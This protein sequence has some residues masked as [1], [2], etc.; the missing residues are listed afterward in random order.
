MTLTTSQW[1]QRYL[2]QAS[3]TQNLRNYIYNQVLIQRADKILDIGCGTGV[4]ENELNR[5]TLSHVYGLDIDLKPLHLA[6]EYAP[7]SNFTVGDCS[8]LPYRN[9][10][11]N[12]TLCHFL[13]LWVKDTLK[14]IE[15]MARVTRPKGFVLALAEPDYGGRIDYP[16]EL[17]RIG[18][19]QINALRHQGANPL[20]GR[21]LRSLFSHAG[22]INIEIGVLGGQW[23]ENE[24]GQDF[25]L[26][27]E[28][29]QSDLNQN[30]EFIRQAGK[31][32]AIDSASRE[33]HQRI[34]FVP[35]FYAIGMIPGSN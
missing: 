19:W 27:W 13:L 21:K 10:E 7:K 5:L 9:G 23:G 16:S 33:M 14:S 35:T 8:S 12:I 22:L 2:Q 3:W 4:L 29:I 34:L 31:L 1:H 28:V 26:E 24:P 20:I 11:F 6:R 17:S 25:K 18:Y 15:E 30:N 32:K